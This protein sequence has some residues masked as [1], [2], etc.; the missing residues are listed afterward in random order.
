MLA[1]AAALTLKLQDLRNSPHDSAAQI[2]HLKTEN[3]RLKSSLQDSSIAPGGDARN[4]EVW[5]AFAWEFGRLSCNTHVGL[6]FMLVNPAHP[7]LPV[8][9]EIVQPQWP[10]LLALW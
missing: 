7:E 9:R 2:E 8:D 4:P 1:P 10:D 5:T 3:E 6:R